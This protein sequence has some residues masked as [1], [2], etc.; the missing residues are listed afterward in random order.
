M[1]VQRGGAPTTGAVPGSA[2]AT[3]SSSSKRRASSRYAATGLSRMSETGTHTILSGRLA[4]ATATATFSTRAD[5]RFF[6]GGAY[7]T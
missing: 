7:T 5:E 1:G 3:A 4:G 6:V 2:V